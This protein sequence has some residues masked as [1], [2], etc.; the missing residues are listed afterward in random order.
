[1]L[2]ANDWSGED[3]KG[4]RPRRPCRWSTRGE[5]LKTALSILREAKAPM[6]SREIVTET[7]KR[8]DMPMPPPKILYQQSSSMNTLLNKRNGKDIV[9]HEGKPLRWSLDC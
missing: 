9:R 8:L 4:R 1:M 6:S 3:V 7:V 5:G 2:F